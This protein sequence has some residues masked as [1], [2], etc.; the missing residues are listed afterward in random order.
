[1]ILKLYSKK[2]FKKR[3]K[4]NDANFQLTVKFL[5]LAD[6]TFVCTT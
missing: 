5:L 6:Y 2:F 1:M 4:G 3:I